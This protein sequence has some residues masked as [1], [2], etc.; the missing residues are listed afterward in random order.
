MICVDGMFAIL[1][2]ASLSPLIIT[3]F[4]AERKARKLG[5]VNQISQAP[6][7]PHNE[8]PKET[9]KTLVQRVWKFV[10][11]LDLVGL[12][13]LGAAVALILLPL[14]LT[15]TAKGGWHNG[16]LLHPSPLALTPLCLYRRDKTVLTHVCCRI[17]DRDARR[18]HRPPLRLHAVGHARRRAPRRTLQVLEEQE[19]HWGGVDWVL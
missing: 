19:L 10:D 2:P 17:D 1:V 5:L 13:I 7:S 18:G 11:A 9:Q 3:L 15:Q 14:T 16:A 8:K 6:S 12:V 4:W